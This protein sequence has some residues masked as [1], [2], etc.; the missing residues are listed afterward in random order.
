MALTA[1]TAVMAAAL[2]RYGGSRRECTPAAQRAVVTA[3]VASADVTAVVV[4]YRGLDT[5][6]EVTILFLTAA[7]I[8]FFLKKQP[9]GRNL[10]TNS[11]IFQTASKVLIPG[12][13]MS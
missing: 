6:G 11:E 8:A 12:T 7:I 10:R 3:V 1:V 5:L 2:V 4:T 13:C 9:E